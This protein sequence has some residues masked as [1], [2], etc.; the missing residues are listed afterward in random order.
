MR[1]LTAVAL[2]SALVNVAMALLA[3]HASKQ[4]TE[5]AMQ[6][7]INYDLWQHARTADSERDICVSML[8]APQ[9]HSFTGQ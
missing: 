4:A 7:T 5:L 9:R 2:V 8:P 3:L 6:R 1:L